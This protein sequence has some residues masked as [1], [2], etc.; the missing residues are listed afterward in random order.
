M[1]PYGRR[2][3][4][5]LAVTLTPWAHVRDQG[6]DAFLPSGWASL[7]TCVHIS[8]VIFSMS[9]KK[10]VEIHQK[11]YLEIWI[12]LT[13][14]NAYSTLGL[15]YQLLS[16]LQFRFPFGA[17]VALQELRLVNDGL[18]ISSCICTKRSQKAQH[19]STKI[20]TVYCTFRGSGS[21]N[22]LQQEVT[23][24]DFQNWSAWMGANRSK[25]LCSDYVW[26]RN[27]GAVLKLW[28]SWLALLRS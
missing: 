11:L 23:H 19:R 4:W 17:R 9:W 8:H 10:E 12:W 5:W 20:E 24:G 16:N 2:P 25:F 18:Y 7:H 3:R 21:R 27:H 22:D 1:A 14:P 26:F 6:T 28:L 15:A 13:P